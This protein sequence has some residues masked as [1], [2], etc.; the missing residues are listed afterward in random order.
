MTVAVIVILLMAVVL[1]MQASKRGDTKQGRTLRN[2]ALVF[3]VL[4]LVVAVLDAMDVVQDHN[5]DIEDVPEE[6]VQRANA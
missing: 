3:M 5:A 6:A 2:I 4:A 1:Y